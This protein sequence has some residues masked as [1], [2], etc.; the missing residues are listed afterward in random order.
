MEDSNHHHNVLIVD[1]D[2]AI[3][4]LCRQCLTSSRVSVALANNVHEAR[5]ILAQNRFDLLIADFHLQGLTALDLVLGLRN[6][7]NLTPVILMSGT[8]SASNAF[9]RADI[10]QW[11]FLD[12]PFHPERFQNL[13]RQLMCDELCCR[14]SPEKN[15]NLP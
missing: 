8:P 12:K 1:E 10:T 6:E 2:P 3:L 14:Q 9:Q 11:E 15:A 4:N 5:Q 13:V 7:G